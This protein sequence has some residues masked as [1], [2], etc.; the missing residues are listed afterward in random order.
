VPYYKKT[1][2]TGWSFSFGH[3]YGEIPPTIKSSCIL[4][5]S[6]SYDIISIIRK[7]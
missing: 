6:I 1:I 7:E 4:T 5:R 3:N 2:L